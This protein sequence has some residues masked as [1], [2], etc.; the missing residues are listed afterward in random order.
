MKP[1]ALKELRERFDAH[2]LAH[3]G[4]RDGDDPAY[5]E[6][7]QQTLLSNDSQ[8]RGAEPAF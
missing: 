2:R 6:F 5:A 8:P 1:K 7:L 4:A 3:L